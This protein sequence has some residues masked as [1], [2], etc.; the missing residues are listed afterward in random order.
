MQVFCDRAW[1]RDIQLEFETAEHTDMTSD[2][3]ASKVVLFL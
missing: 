3:A 2:A 1:N